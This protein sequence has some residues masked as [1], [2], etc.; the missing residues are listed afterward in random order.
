MRY[1]AVTDGTDA[2]MAQS[3]FR[4][5]AFFMGSILGTEFVTYFACIRGRNLDAQMRAWK[6]EQ[7]MADIV[8]GQDEHSQL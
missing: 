6:E 7:R 5:V 4:R 2:V 8:R 1:H 3:P